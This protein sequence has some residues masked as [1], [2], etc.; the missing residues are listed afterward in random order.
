M[1]SI[2]RDQFTRIFDPSNTG[3]IDD[4][5]VEAVLRNQR[6]V[7]RGLDEELSVVLAPDASN[8]RGM[9][10]Y[11]TDFRRI[12]VCPYFTQESD[13]TRKARNLVHELAHM[14]LLVYDR[15]YYDPRSY[16]SRYAALTP[17]GA[18]TARIPVIGPVFRELARSDT[19]YHPDAYAWFGAVL[20]Y[21]EYETPVWLR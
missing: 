20:I 14:K 9:Q 17:R 3:D 13:S 19:L 21:P 15:P 12:Y 11:Y 16:S 1:S 8:C 2:E 18:W 4:S 10:L 6:R 5:F 7:R